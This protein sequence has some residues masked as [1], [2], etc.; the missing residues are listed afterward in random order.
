MKELKKPLDINYFTFPFFVV[1][2]KFGEGCPILRILTSRKSDLS[3]RTIRTDRVMICN[4]ITNGTLLTC[5]SPFA[6]TSR[7][8]VPSIHACY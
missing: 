1:T 4:V 6:F 2:P 7:K 8:V 5:E 3:S